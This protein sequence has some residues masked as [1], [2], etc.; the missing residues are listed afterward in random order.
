MHSRLSIDSQGAFFPGFLM[1]LLDNAASSIVS[2]SASGIDEQFDQL[3]EIMLRHKSTLRTVSL[4]LDPYDVDHHVDLFDQFPEAEQPGEFANLVFPEMD[5]L[6]MI[7]TYPGL[8]RPLAIAPASP[9]DSAHLADFCQVESSCTLPTIAVR[10]TVMIPDTINI[11]TSSRFHSVDLEMNRSATNN[12]NP[13]TIQLSPT[14]HTLTLESRF[15]YT[16]TIQPTSQLR[17]LDISLYTPSITTPV[18]SLIQSAS[19]LESLNIYIYPALPIDIIT[20]LL[21]TI[22]I[23]PR[24][25]SLTISIDPLH[26]TLLLDLLLTHSFTIQYLCIGNNLPVQLP[27]TVFPRVIHTSKSTIGYRVLQ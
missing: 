10:A 26:H 4:R 19:H 18:I 8:A 9:L 1:E 11:L 20:D 5:Y 25:I 16:L 12:H 27:S 21:H 23:H 15:F 24:L 17:H 2:F 6:T 22:A 3:I 14:I 13:A 7:A